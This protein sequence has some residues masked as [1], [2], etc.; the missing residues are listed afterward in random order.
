MLVNLIQFLRYFTAMK[1]EVD[2][3]DISELVNVPTSQNNLKNKVDDLDVGK[4]KTVT[5][6]LKKDAASKEVIKKTRVKQVKQ[7]DNFE[8][9][10]PDVSTFLN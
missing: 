3:L 5:V 6:D 4:L 1:A 9:K 8:N 10:I 2:K 7:V